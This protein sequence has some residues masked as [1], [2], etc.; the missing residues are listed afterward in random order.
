MRKTIDFLFDS[1]SHIIY[2]MFILY[3]FGFLLP[4]VIQLIFVRNAIAVIVL[5]CICL[6][7]Q[8]FFAGVEIIQFKMSNDNY[9]SNGQNIFDWSLIILYVVYFVLRVMDPAKEMI[10]EEGFTDVIMCLWSVVNT[11][12]LINASIKW[13][14]FAMIFEKFGMMYQM[15][16]D[17]ISEV[18]EFFAFLAFWLVMFS[19]LF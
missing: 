13:L 6:M 12:I 16:K 4:F 3:M 8:L 9:M 18:K 7:T 19:F 1:T 5:N 14:N 10:P 2:R 15:I 17:V 11:L